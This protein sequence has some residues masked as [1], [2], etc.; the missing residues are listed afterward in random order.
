[1]L[2][3]ISVLI[4]SFVVLVWSADR[5]VVGAAA[6]ARHWGVSP[7]LIGL[8]IVAIGTSAP[9]M[10]VS[11][12]AALSG[13]PELGVGNALGSNIANIALVLGCASLLSPIVVHSDLLKREFPLLLL[14]SVVVGLIL[15]DLRLQ[16]FEGLLLLVG[17]VLLMVWLVFQGLRARKPADVIEVEFKEELQE[18]VPKQLSLS[19][20]VLW[21]VV[22]IV[23]LPLS[24]RGLVWGS[25]FIAD[26]FGISE[27][28]IGLTIVAIGTSLPEL[29]AAIVGVIKKHDDLALG[30]IL[31]SNMF[32]SLAVLGLPAAISPLH[33]DPLVLFRDYGLMMAL[34]VG[35]FVLS[36]GFSKEHG[37]ISRLNGGVFLVIYFGY[38]VLLYVQSVPAA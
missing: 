6:L 18:H 1:M 11:S 10:L 4:V 35:L 12:I 15:L 27:L 33:L 26:F 29:A 30:T 25:V 9:E 16:R 21:V 7:L 14:I 19:M 17:F 24:A 3:V 36:Y 2:L 20:A 32:N 34:T 8:T 31:G 23:L 5:F 37:R 38:L 13:Q 28:V 22:G